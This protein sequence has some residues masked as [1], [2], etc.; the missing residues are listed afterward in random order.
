VTAHCP[1]SAKTETIDLVTG[2]P[3]DPAFVRQ[4]FEDV[5]LPL[6]TAPN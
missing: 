1:A 2:K 6:V 3:L 5:T 4:V